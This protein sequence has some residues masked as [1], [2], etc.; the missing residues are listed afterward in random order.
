MSGNLSHFLAEL[1]SNPE[2]MA[3]YLADPERVF[4]EAGLTTDE[5]EVIRSRDARRLDEVLSD[6]FRLQSFANNDVPVPKKAPAK[7]KKPA[8]KKPAKKKGGRKK[9]GSKKR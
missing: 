1:V 3:A 9:G 7:R 8:A 2:Q 6:G 5:R 4:D